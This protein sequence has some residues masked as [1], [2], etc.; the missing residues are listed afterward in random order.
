MPRARLIAIALVALLA[1]PGVASAAE[2]V[3]VSGTVRNVDTTPAPGVEVLVGV[4]GT[5][6][7]QP[8]TTDAAGAFAA[9]IEA[10]PGDTIEI[11]ATGATV[12]SEPDEEGCVH[13]TTPTGRASFVLGEGA[14]GPV[15]VVLDTMLESTVC[16]TTATPEP[17]PRVTPPATDRPGAGASGAGSGLAV[18]LAVLG[19]LVAAGWLAARRRAA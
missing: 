11:R 9:Q 3:D 1:L 15:E 6:I 13:A 12:R 10:A 4:A 2:L 16:T 5:D 18:A 8:V 19:S 17:T 7:F 14:P